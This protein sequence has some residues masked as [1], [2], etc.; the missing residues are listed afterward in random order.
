MNLTATLDATRFNDQMGRLRDAFIGA[1]Q[2]GDAAVIVADE[3]RKF[4]IQCMRFTPPKSLEQ[5]RKAVNRDILRAMTPL[6]IETI[7]NKR[8]RSILASRDNEAFRS[9]QAKSKTFKRWRV[10]PF[11]PDRLH[12]RVRD[13]RG[14]VQREKKVFVL[15]RNEVARYIAAKQR[16][17]GYMRSGW[18]PAILALGGRLPAWVARHRHNPGF[19]VSALH[20]ASPSVTIGN[21]ANGI[22]RI[23]HIA[24][25]ALRARERAIRR[26]VKLVLSL[27]AK[28]VA[29]GL[30]I[31]RKAS[32]TLSTFE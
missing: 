3:A 22:G 14:R 31:T 29:H 17:V 24:E 8:L 20:G 12:K 10:E 15:E 6:D 18:A 32:E 25:S 11:D 13:R 28:D 1:G 7:K 5:G 26:R 27:Y 4:A 23:R 30:K 2:I 19:V 16:Q 21:V 9:F